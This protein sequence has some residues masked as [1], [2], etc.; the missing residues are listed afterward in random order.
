MRNKSSSLG[1]FHQH[2]YKQLL[3]AQIPK[4]YKAMYVF[5]HFWDLHKNNLLLL[6]T[7]IPSPNQ[8]YITIILSK[9]QEKK[10]K[11]QGESAN[12]IAS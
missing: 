12:L 9:L 5:L 7:F 8:K 1:R 10:I 3:Q 11:E 2:V 6:K 4:G